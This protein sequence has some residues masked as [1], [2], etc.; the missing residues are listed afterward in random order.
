V[1]TNTLSVTVAARLKALGCEQ[2]PPLV[3]EKIE[4]DFEAAAAASQEKLAQK[5]ITFSSVSK[6]FSSVIRS[7]KAA[8]RKAPKQMAASV[9]SEAS[10]SD[11]ASEGASEGASDGA[12]EDA[13]APSGEPLLV[14]AGSDKKGWFL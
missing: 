4:S 6:A 10:G 5:L 14:E 13:P 12:S 7:Q 3:R 8:V 11:G 2:I 1:K 9:A